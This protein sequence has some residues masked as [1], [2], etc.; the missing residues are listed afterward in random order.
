[1][2]RFLQKVSLFSGIFL[3][4]GVTM[5]VFAN[6]PGVVSP[7]TKASNNTSANKQTKSSPSGTTSSQQG[8]SQVRV[9]QIRVP[10]PKALQ[11]PLSLTGSCRVFLGAWVST[12]N[13]AHL[14]LY[15]QGSYRLQ[16]S[17]GDGGLVEE[18]GHWR[19]HKLKIHLFPFQKGKICKSRHYSFGRNNALIFLMHHGRLAYTRSNQAMPTPPVLR[20]PPVGGQQRRPQG[21]QNNNNDQQET[22]PREAE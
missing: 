3:V 20:L 2:E 15:Q 14:F 7:K 21:H 12:Q 19:C 13:K 1:M 22:Q 17:Q 8:R 9:V 4:F 10:L 6:Q 18:V 11:T 5:P 16:R